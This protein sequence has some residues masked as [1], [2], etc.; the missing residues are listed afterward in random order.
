MDTGN[1][2]KEKHNIK[3]RDKLHASSGKRKHIHTEKV[4]KQKQR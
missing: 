1:Y 4:N 2:I 3:T